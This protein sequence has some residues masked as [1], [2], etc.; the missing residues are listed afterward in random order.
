MKI[1][2]HKVFDGDYDDSN[3]E[4]TPKA[5][6]YDNSE[7]EQRNELEIADDERKIVIR[8]KRKLKNELTHISEGTEDNE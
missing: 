1:D 7:F 6:R 8:N 4:S 2:V 5:K 3:Y